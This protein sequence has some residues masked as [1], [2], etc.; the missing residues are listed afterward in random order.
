MAS[1]SVKNET[2]H[3]TPR[4]SY[5][6]I[7]EEVLP[8]WE[9]SLVFMEPKKAAALNVQLRR[10]S[11]VPNVLSYALGEE[12]GEI[13]ICPAEAKRQAPEY[14][15]AA[16]TFVLYLFIHAL[17]HLKGWG[18]GVTMER[19]EERLVA[20]FATRAKRTTHGAT[21]SNRN[22]HR[23]LSSKGGRR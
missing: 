1:L 23:H 21:H 8:G 20:K 4:F 5:S 17:L 19:C 18:H 22:R 15:M 2:R 7:I 9:I 6:R 3:T 10:K 12:S 11:Y 16:S 14:G 13:V